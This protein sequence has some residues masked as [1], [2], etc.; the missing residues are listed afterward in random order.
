M[1]PSSLTTSTTRRL[2]KSSSRTNLATKTR[3][4]R[5][6]LTPNSTMG[7]S[8][9]R[10]LHHCSFRS[11]KNQRTEDKLITLME[12]V[13]CQLSPFL[14]V[15]QERGDPCMNLVRKVRAA[16]KNQLAKWKT[17]KSGFSLKD[18]KC[19]MQHAFDFVPHEC[20]TARARVSQVCGCLMFS[21][22]PFGSW[23]GGSLQGAGVLFF[24]GL[25]VRSHV[26]VLG[27][28]RV[29]A[30]NRFEI[31]GAR[32]SGGPSGAH[33]DRRAAA[34]DTAR[35]PGRYTN[36]GHGLAVHRQRRLENDG[37]SSS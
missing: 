17:K 9:K 25:R 12:K 10:S 14:C 35:V 15:T 32:T 16:E 24:H 37:K 36:T 6:R 30:T 29:L 26:G 7:P 20:C 1:S 19:T 22:R 31:T 4:S 33:R 13:C 21:L 11:E 2:L 28:W 34:R 3:Y 8:G 5:T 27:S 23:V 18:K